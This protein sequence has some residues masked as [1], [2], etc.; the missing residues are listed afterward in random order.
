[1][2][3]FKALGKLLSESGGPEMLTESDALAPGSLN[4]FL[5]G[6]HFNR[7]KRLHPILALAFE[8]LHF[9]AFLETYESKD[10]IVDHIGTNNGEDLPSITTSDVFT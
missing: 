6:K 7:C 3:F 1:M 9:L 10:E 5:K 4:G 2:A 8:I